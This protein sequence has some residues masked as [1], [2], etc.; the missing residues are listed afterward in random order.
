MKKIEERDF[1]ICAEVGI[2]VIVCVV[3]PKDENTQKCLKEIDDLDLKKYYIKSYWYNVMTDYD[4]MEKF[5]IINPPVVLIFKDGNLKFNYEYKTPEDL[6][7]KL[8]SLAYH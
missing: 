3:S 4:K 2:T 8:K 1:E 7:K 6:T 5:N